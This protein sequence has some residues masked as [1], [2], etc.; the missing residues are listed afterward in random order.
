MNAFDLA[1]FAVS[2]LGALAF[3]FVGT[4]FL[5]FCERFVHARVQHRD[6]PGRQGQT[7]FFQVWRDFQKTRRK[8]KGDLSR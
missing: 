2:A 3:L 7:D 6:G 1:F 4:F 5:L 8:S